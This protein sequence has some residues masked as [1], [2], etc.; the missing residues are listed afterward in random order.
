MVPFLTAALV[1]SIIPTTLRWVPGWYGVL[2]LVIFATCG[3]A[4]L[5]YIVR[6]HRDAKRRHLVDWT[7]DL[8]RLDSDEFEWLACEL[9]RRE[10]Y[11]SQK[12]GSPHHGDGNIDLKLRRGSENLLVQCKRWAAAY[13]GVAVV[14]EFAGTYPKAG[15]VTGRILLTLSDFTEEGRVAAERAGITLIDGTE[16][17]MRLQRVRRTEPCEKCGTPMLLDRST[18]GWWLRCPRFRAGCD[19][20]RDLSRDPGRAIDLLLDQPP[21]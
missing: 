3:F 1:G 21:S 11:E 10:G 5:A 12:V 8:R 18:R 13:V 6:L 14:R 17:A 2:D 19:G 4:G 15:D 7:S 16:L 9:F 20:K